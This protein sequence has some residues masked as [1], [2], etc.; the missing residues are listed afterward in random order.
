MDPQLGEIKMKTLSTIIAV[1]VI[2]GIGAVGS[3][4]FACDCQEGDIQVL[5]SERHYT[6]GDGRARTVPCTIVQKC[7]DTSWLPTGN[8]WVTIY[9]SCTDARPVRNYDGEQRA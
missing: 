6:D 4:T 2:L 1:A 9:N 7:E 3:I 8:E 5:H